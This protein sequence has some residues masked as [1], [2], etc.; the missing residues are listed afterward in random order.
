MPSSMFG[1]VDKRADNSTLDKELVSLL[2]IFVRIIPDTSVSI[3]AWKHP[4]SFIDRR[5]NRA[6]AL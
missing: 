3:Q 6:V 2:F 5:N 1:A 4:V